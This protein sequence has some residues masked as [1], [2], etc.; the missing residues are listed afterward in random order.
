MSLVI[1][2]NIHKKKGDSVYVNLINV[3]IAEGKVRSCGICE[4]VVYRIACSASNI[5][6][7]GYN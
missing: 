1:Q 7:M 4:I 3:H 5:Y 2:C 6:N